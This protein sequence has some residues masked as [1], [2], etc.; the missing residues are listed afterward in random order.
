MIFVVY[1]S[2][3]SRLI[4]NDGLMADT[5]ITIR[6]DIEIEKADMLSGCVKWIGQS[7]DSKAADKIK[8]FCFY[9]VNFGKSIKLKAHMLQ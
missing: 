5:I 7:T 2:G 8:S 6:Y 4:F 3:R 9:S 1:I